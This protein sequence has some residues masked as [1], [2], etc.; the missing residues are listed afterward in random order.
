MYWTWSVTYSLLLMI[1]FSIEFT[2]NVVL[3]QQ[4]DGHREDITLNRKYPDYKPRSRKNIQTWGKKFIM[5]KNCITSNFRKRCNK[6][7]EGVAKWYP[8]DK[9][10][11]R[12][13]PSEYISGWMEDNEREFNRCLCDEVVKLCFCAFST[14]YTVANLTAMSNNMSTTD[15]QLTNL[16]SHNISET[17]QTL[18][19]DLHQTDLA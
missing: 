9:V 1:G 18:R 2:N 11:T 10:S 16:I 8:F 13:H 19:S 5:G 12:L 6:S 15:I 17:V 7:I 4:L 3:L 14:F